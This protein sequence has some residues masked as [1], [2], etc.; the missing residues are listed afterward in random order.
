M[1][2]IKPQKLGIISGPGSEYF[3]GKVVK[4]LRRLYLERYYKLSSALAKRHGISE[5]EILKTVTLTDDLSNKRIPR[6]KAPT[7]FQCPDFTIKTKYVRFAN[8]EVKAEILDPV[9]GLRVFIIHDLSNN[10]PVRVSGSDEPLRLT[11]NDHL[12]FLL[13]TINALTL[14]GADSV[15][16]VIPT[17]PYSRQHKK[18]TREALTAAMLGR[19]FEMLKVERIITLDIHSREIENSFGHLHLENLH[20]SYQTLIALRKLVDFSDPN[21]VVVAPDTGAI[22]RNKFYAQALHRP[23]AML[24]KERDYSV[25]SKDARNSNIKSINLLGDVKG[26][27]VLIAD[28]ML[29]TGGTMIVAM[30]E[31]TN[32]GA[33]KIICMVSLPYFNGTAVEDFDQAYREGIFYRIIGTNAVTHGRDLLDKEW[34]IQADITELFARV[35][36]R[37]HHGRSI[38]PL[39]DNRRFIQI[40]IDNTQANPKAPLPDAAATD[41][42][43]ED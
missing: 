33:E 5:E 15:T 23:L 40:L 6:S 18:S 35:I 13:T 17:Y 25:V 39:L 34:Y 19:I 20:A 41:P 37:L 9:R 10:E 22:S 32:L 31:L 4:H 2:I 30:R 42:D 8:G 12:V 29:A 43:Q 26:K 7:T 1:S 14:A 28:D 11:I 27:T 36:S 16:L 38:S 21:L 3:T 24:Y